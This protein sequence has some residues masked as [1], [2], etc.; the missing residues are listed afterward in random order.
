MNKWAFNNASEHRDIVNAIFNQGGGQLN[1]YVL[2]PLP[3]Y[4]RES[5]LWRHQQM[6]NDMNSVLGFVGNDLSSVDFNNKHQLD[7]WLLLHYQEHSQARSKL[8][9]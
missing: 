3:I 2:D 5:W 1:L 7:A 6:H 4:D 8:R 9:I